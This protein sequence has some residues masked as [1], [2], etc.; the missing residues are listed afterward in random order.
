MVFERTEYHSIHKIISFGPQNKKICQ[1]EQ[2]DPPFTKS[3]PCKTK[4]VM[5]KEE[6]VICFHH[7]LCQ[8]N[9]MKEIVMYHSVALLVAR[10]SGNLGAMQ[11]V[12]ESKEWLIGTKYLAPRQQL[13]GHTF[14]I[15]AL[16]GAVSAFHTHLFNNN[17]NHRHYACKSTDQNNCHW[18]GLLQSKWDSSLYQAPSW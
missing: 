9:E 16:V 17:P 12:F 3:L 11:C 18:F 7:I 15:E 6:T 8:C 4:G 13:Q 5:A 10:G 2:D 14:F 1:I